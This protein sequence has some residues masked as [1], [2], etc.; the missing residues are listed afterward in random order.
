MTRR[1]VRHRHLDRVRRIAGADAAT[2]AARKG[3]QHAECWSAPDDS[4]RG[5][6]TGGDNID[7]PILIHNERVKGRVAAMSPRVRFAAS[8][9]RG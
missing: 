6:G 8:D 2:P 4:G 7:T 9:L 3:I 5:A 1:R